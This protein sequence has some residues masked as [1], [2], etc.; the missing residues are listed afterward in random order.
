MPPTIPTTTMA[1]ASPLR[2][3]EPLAATKNVDYRSKMNWNKTI[4]Q[5]NFES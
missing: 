3:A 2:V 4:E 1:P 5:L